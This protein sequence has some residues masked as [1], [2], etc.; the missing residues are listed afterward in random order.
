MGGTNN[1]MDLLSLVTSVL[2][3]GEVSSPDEDI[4]RVVEGWRENETHNQDVPAVSHK[5]G[6][7]LF[8]FIPFQDVHI[9][10]ES[11]DKLSFSWSKTKVK[12]NLSF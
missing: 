8:V 7:T 4:L 3:D 1:G 6:L 10:S 11:N 12:E 5:R 9:I 2:N